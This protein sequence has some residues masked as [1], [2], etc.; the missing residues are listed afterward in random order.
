MG[1]EEEW[2][3]GGGGLGGE[4]LG[5]LSPQQELS[6]SI[7]CLFRTDKQAKETGQ[8]FVY[9][10]EIQQKIFLNRTFSVIQNKNIQ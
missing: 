9:R 6:S 1:E 8:V 2:G 7:I 4:G 10:L 3:G 5:N